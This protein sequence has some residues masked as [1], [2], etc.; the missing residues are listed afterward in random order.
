MSVE[1]RLSKTLLNGSEAGLMFFRRTE[2]ETLHG[3]RIDMQCYSLSRFATTLGLEWRSRVTQTRR[4]LE[5]L[6]PSLATD[7]AKLVY[8]EL[9]ESLAEA[10]SALTALVQAISRPKLGS[11]GVVIESV[12]SF[13]LIE[14][15]GRNLELLAAIAYIQRM[16]GIFDIRFDVRG[17]L[18]FSLELL[19]DRD[20]RYR[21]NV[22]DA[23]GIM[24]EPANY[25]N[26]ENFERSGAELAP[27]PKESASMQNIEADPLTMRSEASTT[28]KLTRPTRVLICDDETRLVTLTAG[29]LREF[30]Y[31][32]LT[33]KSG[34]DA[35]NCVS[36]EAVDVVI[37][38]VNLPGEDTLSVARRLIQNNAPAIVLSSGFTEEDVESE[39][40]SLP[41]V[42]AFLAK[43]YGIDAL[44]ATI[45]QVV[46]KNT[47]NK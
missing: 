40:L 16:G 44:S 13:E 38:D 17:A 29:L 25:T 21:A 39:L 1:C 41:G 37:L 3:R 4:L 10:Q 30:G 43:P 12:N 47:P 14:A 11:D 15:S 19:L 27:G 34:E 8:A 45:R 9:N 32:V 2:Q 20:D 36:R 7:E 18:C 28:S 6:S 5:R 24:Q 22:Q 42:Q 33:V 26:G 35:I 23:E 31:E 46:E